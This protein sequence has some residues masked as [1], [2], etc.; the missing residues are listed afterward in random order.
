MIEVE[1]MKILK[2]EDSKG[3]FRTSA[4]AEWKEID[5]IDKGGLMALLDTFL[6]SDAEM[7]SPDENEIRNPAQQI[8]YRSIFEKLSNLSENK[9]KFKDESDRKYLKEMKKYSDGNPITDLAEE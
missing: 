7:D 8:V 3:Y 1:A 9:K 5:T 4:E 2:I 6:E